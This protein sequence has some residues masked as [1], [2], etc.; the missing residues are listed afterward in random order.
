MNSRDEAGVGPKNFST[1]IGVLKVLIVLLT[2]KSLVP[3]L[4]NTCLMFIIRETKPKMD[5]EINI[6]NS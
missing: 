4:L 2:K 3:E 5:Y 6:N 1:W